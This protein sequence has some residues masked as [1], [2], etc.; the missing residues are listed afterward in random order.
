MASYDI[1]T[2]LET[3]TSL[4][5]Y[6]ADYGVVDVTWDI[7]S[8]SWSEQR[9]VRSLSGYAIDETQGDLIFDE[10][11]P[12]TTSFTDSVLQGA[13]YYYTLILFSITMQKWV[14]AGTSTILSI[15]DYGYVDR[16]YALLPDVYKNPTLQD[17]GNSTET[18]DTS[19][20]RYLSLIGFQFDFSRTVTDS[21]LLIHNPMELI[22]NFL[23][24]ALGD[25]NLD[26]EPE[27]GTP[28]MR[29]YLANAV[30]LYKYKGTDTAASELTTILTGWGAGV[31]I[32]KNM[33]LDDLMACQDG[34]VGLWG[35]T[36]VNASVTYLPNNPGISGPYGS[37]VVQS[38]VSGYNS[39]VR[40]GIYDYTAGV[41]T[42]CQ[43]GIPVVQGSD[44]CVSM[45]FQATGPGV[46][47]VLRVTWV[48]V[49]GVA[50][51]T[52]TQDPPTALSRTS[53]R[54]ASVSTNA[55]GTAAFALVDWVATSSVGFVVNDL[56][57][58]NAFQFEAGLSPTSF[59]CARKILIIAQ[60]DVVNYVV[61]P[62]GTIDNYGWESSTGA[63]AQT[64][65]SS[66]STYLTFTNSGSN[67]AQQE[68]YSGESRTPVQIG[69]VWSVQ[70]QTLDSEVRG[71]RLW[72][73]SVL[74][75]YYRGQFV[76]DVVG[77]WSSIVNNVWTTTATTYEVVTTEAVT[78][79]EP[80]IVFQYAN[81]SA[82]AGN[83]IIN[84]R[85]VAMESVPI[86]RIV[87]ADGSIPSSTGDY[88]WGGVPG[89]SPTYYYRN[90]SVKASRLLTILPE[91]L[92]YGV[93]FDLVFA[94]STT[95]FHGGGMAI[96]N[97]D[98]NTG[99]VLNYV[100]IEAILDLEWNVLVA[101]EPLDIDLEWSF[102]PDL[103]LRWNVLENVTV[104]TAL[105]WNVL[106]SSTPLDLALEWNVLQS[107]YVH[108]DMGLEW[109]VN[110]NVS[111]SDNFTRA[112]G[113]LGVTSTS[114]LPWS[115][116]QSSVT[117]NGN[118]ADVKATGA[119]SGRSIAV[120]QAYENGVYT[121]T[122]PSSIPTG[123]ESLYFRV[124][125]ANN[126]WRLR[127]TSTLESYEYISS[128]SCTYNTSYSP[129]GGGTSGSYT[130]STDQSGTTS[131]SGPTYWNC[132]DFTSQYENGSYVVTYESTNYYTAVNQSNS[133][134][135]PNGGA[136]VYSTSCSG[137]YTS[138][139][140]TTTSCSP[141]YSTEYYYSYALTLDKCV[142]GTITSTVMGSLTNTGTMK[143]TLLGS[144]ITASD[145]TSTQAAVTDTFNQSAVGVG[146][147]S[148]ASP[149]S[150]TDLYFTGLAGSYTTVGG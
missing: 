6:L 94:R 61:N 70:V 115:V 100:V 35:Q 108:S 50:L 63:V 73:A 27:L 81:G 116:L 2:A 91:Y 114:S 39:Y 98:I 67:A 34:G 80:G 51:S 37:G 118:K 145:G 78:D 125:D 120:V 93:C 117:I 56:I 44:Y 58:S 136:T 121:A 127:V 30:H 133:G 54:R 57:Y 104:D 112:N 66:G 82:F 10:V 75:L 71:T 109:N 111:F 9:L 113:T 89:Q 110:D 141:N 25:F 150:N 11:D 143:V 144:S 14:V 59:E 147:G 23:P 142:A 33:A 119:E 62:T 101:S 41:I 46:S 84:F 105:E 134:S 31:S 28:V 3:S 99:T 88:L 107:F 69:D 4:V 43:Q 18:T 103:I 53:M 122:M 32:G 74:R 76:R 55:P 135:S 92:P 64:V 20:Y 87:Y 83:E 1:A 65:A 24:A 7:P 52:T 19:L 129:Q 68:I 77:P 126:W 26:Y 146:I 131:G 130:S 38:R 21:L 96:E 17:L 45:Y 47:V 124:S 149:T 138:T 48:D 86:A 79:V 40:V 132:N 13:F 5:T 139:A 12:A 85:Q 102:E 97:Y 128:Y 42:Q 137:P 140:S 16:Q 15:N 60:A 49:N 8:G 22:A 29:R 95:P 148:G 90:R 72:A 36:S 106:V 123:G